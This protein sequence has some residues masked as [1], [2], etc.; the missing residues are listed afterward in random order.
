MELEVK[1]PGGLKHLKALSLANSRARYPHMPES[2]RS[3]RS[4]SD[5]T[6]NGLQKCIID[7]LTFSLHQAERISSAGR[8]IDSSK[9]ITDCLGSK[10]R[11]GSGKW[12][13]GSMQKGSADISATINGRS[14]KIEVKM[15]DSQSESQKK[16]QEQV[17]KAGGLYWLVRSFDEF[18]NFYNDLK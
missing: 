12:I 17:E 1:K 4:Y 8:Y 9:V 3:C 18:L 6:A 7:F 5:R 14:V 16:Y 10:R 11:I 15:K 13:P 2:V